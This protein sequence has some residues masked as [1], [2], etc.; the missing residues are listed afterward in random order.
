M[1]WLDVDY[2]YGYR[3]G[4]YDLTAAGWYTSHL[5]ELGYE[6][7]RRDRERDEERGYLG[8]GN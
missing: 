8:P 1:S 6:D 5:Y 7:G 3:N 2:R 4:Y